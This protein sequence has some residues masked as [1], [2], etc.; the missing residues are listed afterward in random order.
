MF[1][2]LRED[3]QYNA[4]ADGGIRHIE[5]RPAVAADME[6]QEVDNRAED[7]AVDDVADGPADAWRCASSK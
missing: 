1:A 6:I 5:G 4:D 3:H 2:Q 7:E